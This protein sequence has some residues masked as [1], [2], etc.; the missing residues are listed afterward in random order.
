LVRPLAVLLA[1]LAFASASAAQQPVASHA[2]GASAPARIREEGR[3]NGVPLASDRVDAAL[4]ALIPMESFHRNVTRASLAALRQRALQNVI[5]EELHY[6]DG[7]RLG[8]TASDAEVDE[9]VARARRESK[10]PAAFDQALRQARVSMADFRKEVRRALTIKKAHDHEVTSRCQVGADEAERF[11]ADNRE[12]FVVPEQLH[13]YAITI[14][15]DPSSSARQWADASARANDVL[16]QIRGGAPF[17]EMARRYSTDPSRDKGGDM[18]L[19][20]RGTLNDEFEKAARG[21]KPGD[22]SDVVQTLYGYHIIRVAEIRPPEQRR[23][24]DMGLEIRKDLTKK[25]CTD[26][27]DAWMARLR[28]GATI[29]LADAAG[30]SRSSPAPPR[31]GRAP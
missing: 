10:N 31:G 20:H 9:D 29:V 11:Y 13:V 24:A 5:D 30:T 15:V 27:A 2:T 4:N 1:S 8:L 7:V 25:R 3:V 18:G 16:R 12:R 23:Y 21:M 19:F 26:M 28:A 17:D 6:Q 22:V 14:G